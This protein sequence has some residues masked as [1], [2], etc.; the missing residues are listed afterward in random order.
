M[1][2]VAETEYRSDKEILGFNRWWLFG[3]AFL[4]MCVISPYEY[5]WASIAPHIGKLYGWDQH[6]LSMMFTT[7]VIFQALGALP[8]GVLRDKF[9]P[10][11][12][13]VAAGIVSAIGL[14]ACAFGDVLSYQ[15]I[16]VLWCIGCFF[17]GFVYNASV[18]TCNKWFPDKRNITV[19]VM[20]AAF[21]WGSL[22]FIFPIR[23][24]PG[25]A[26]PSV[27]FD[28][29]YVMT[30]VIAGVI[31][32][33]GLL[34]K[35][36]PA[37]WRPAGWSP[38]GKKSSKRACNK[39]Y[40][41]TETMGTWQFW[42]LLASFLFVSSAGL[43]FIAQIIKFS[44][45]YGFGAVAATVGTT[46][47]AVTSGLSRVVAGWIAEKI[48]VIKTMTFFYSLTGAF[49]F[50]A[51]YF[52]EAGNAWGFVLSCVVS[53]FFW[54][55]LYSLFASIIGL[56]YGDVASGSNYGLI[57]AIAKGC[58]GIYGGVFSGWMIVNYGHSETIAVSAIMAVL[59]GLIL[60]P[61]WNRPPIWKSGAV[62]AVTV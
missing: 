57:Y 12:V 44:Q 33:T 40:S 42:I 29:I 8:G 14:L 38:S 6:K 55:A 32:L 39:Q 27:F 56:Y 36:P 7:F 15:T 61:L 48:G 43:C 30:A 34:M 31:I 46:G 26:A 54:G 16:L 35:D 51:L 5:A 21:S 1:G 13:S 24:I 23:A 49:A 47:I 4:A 52:A 53:I 45:A 22:P 11:P 25:D 9:G 3:L 2:P 59:S 60:I 17:C 41:M 18:T 19:G 58:G 20:S 28:V 50:L 10:R 37:G 62:A